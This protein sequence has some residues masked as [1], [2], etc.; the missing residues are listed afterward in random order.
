MAEFQV[1][2]R[3]LEGRPEAACGLAAE[4]RGLTGRNDTIEHAGRAV[5]QRERIAL[6]GAGGWGPIAIGTLPVGVG[7][8]EAV[9][10]GVA[11][12]ICLTLSMWWVGRQHRRRASTRAGWGATAIGVGQFL[13][14]AGSLSGSQ[15]PL[16][17][18]LAVGF[19]AFSLSGLLLVVRDRD[20]LHRSDRKRRELPPAE[21]CKEKRCN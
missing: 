2:P 12:L 20:T 21:G 19:T 3:R 13:H 5:R 9:V 1:C 17:L 8:F 7:M 15:Q 6:F 16:G 14:A 11:G 18:I 4:A 10:F